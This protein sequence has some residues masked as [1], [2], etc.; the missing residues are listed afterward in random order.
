MSVN[1]LCTDFNKLVAPVLVVCPIGMM[2]VLMICR[3]ILVGFIRKNKGRRKIWD[4][5]DVDTGKINDIY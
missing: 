5:L 4:E 3:S 2:K 1:Q